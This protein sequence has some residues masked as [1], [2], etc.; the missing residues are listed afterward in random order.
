MDWS[1]KS[2]LVIAVTLISCLA[3]ADNKQQESAALIMRAKQLSDLRAEGSPAFRLKVRFKIT[4]DNSTAQE[5][6]YTEVWV[7]REQCWR[8]T[9]LGDFRRTK[10]GKTHKGW[11]LNSSS[12]VPRLRF[13]RL[14]YPTRLELAKAS[15]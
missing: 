9:V 15:P 8:E 5:G 7:S 13:Q 14:S 11:T 3:V 12:T 1:R 4:K 2:K 6:T 10:V